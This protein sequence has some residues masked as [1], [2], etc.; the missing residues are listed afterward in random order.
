MKKKICL[1]LFI[2]LI[3]I[4]SVI[5]GM[6]LTSCSIWNKGNDKPD[7]KDGEIEQGGNRVFSFSEYVGTVSN[8]GVGYTATDWLN[9]KIGATPVHDKQGDVVLFFID[10]G[11]YS[12]GING[13]A[14][15]DL[16]E[17]F[18]T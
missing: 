5:A 14:D 8:P 6:F 17:Q 15:Y 12:L 9:A 11:A 3:F 4:V 13:V 18:F 2:A 10:I 1:N 7:D 16:D